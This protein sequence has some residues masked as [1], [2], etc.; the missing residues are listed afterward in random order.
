[1]SQ[2]F[3]KLSKQQRQFLFFGLPFLT[4]MVGSTVMLGQLTQTR[5]DLNDKKVQAVSKEEELKLDSNRKRLNLQ[6]EYFKLAANEGK[7]WDYVRVPR[8][9]GIEEPIFKSH[10]SMDQ[11]GI[12]RV[13]LSKTLACRISSHR[14][15][16]AQ[17]SLRCDWTK[18]EPIQRVQSAMAAG[19][20]S[21]R[22]STTL[23]KTLL[24]GDGLAGGGT[25]VHALGNT[26]YTCFMP[27]DSFNRDFSA[28]IVARALHQLDIPAHVNA[29][30]DIVVDNRKV[31]GSAFKVVHEKA[32]AHGTMLI[33]SDLESLGMQLKSP[34]KGALVGKGVESFPSKV[35]RLIDHSYTVTHTDFCRAVAEEFGIVYNKEAGLK[36]HMTE[37]G[38]AD[39]NSNPKMQEY[40]DEIKTFEWKWG[41]TPTFTHA[42][43]KEF[44]W[45]HLKSIVTISEGVIVEVASE[46][47]PSSKAALPFDGKFL[48]DAISTFLVGTRYDDGAVGTWD[49]L[50]DVNRWEMGIQ[51]A[52]D[53][54]EWLQNAIWSGIDSVESQP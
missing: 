49:T 36:N 11:P 20:S 23:S 9:A 17:Q 16:V 53:V 34:R 54:Y 22:D 19:K 32:Y 37:L 27:R 33:S 39:F 44:R 2:H 7:D 21:T 50:N 4:T 14:I 30:H 6:E 3:R 13:A 10:R 5:Y 29:R 52:G 42:I 18:P 1:M 47:T 43:E 28:N 26:N 46:V 31:S 48:P 45:G 25:V 12:R 24:Y 35:T 41:Q 40:Y 8:P 15:P 51:N 38:M